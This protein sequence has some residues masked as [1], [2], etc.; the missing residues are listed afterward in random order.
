MRLCI[1]G[2]S[3]EPLGRQDHTISPSASMLHV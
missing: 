1:V 3:A 2:I